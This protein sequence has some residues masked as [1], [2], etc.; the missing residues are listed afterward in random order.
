MLPLGSRTG[1]PACMRQHRPWPGRWLGQGIHVVTPNKRLGSGPLREYQ[2]AMQA[3][4]S[5][6]GMFFCEARPLGAASARLHVRQPCPAHRRGRGPGGGLLVREAHC[7][8]NRAAATGRACEGA[9][10]GSC[11]ELCLQA[12]GQ[13]GAALPAKVMWYSHP[14]S[15]V[16]LLM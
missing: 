14:L 10:W 9:P 13:T 1:A 3:A 7:R 6:G 2:A 16:L 11:R 5:G 12:R 4:R 15:S 8:R